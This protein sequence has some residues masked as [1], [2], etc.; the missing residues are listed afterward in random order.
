MSDFNKMTT[1]QLAEILKGK[2]LAVKS[3][4][5]PEFKVLPNESLG[6]KVVA[7]FGLYNSD[8]DKEARPL[9]LESIRHLHNLQRTYLINRRASPSEYDFLRD[10]ETVRKDRRRVTIKGWVMW[11]GQH[12]E[13]LKDDPL[14]KEIVTAGS[15]FTLGVDAETVNKSPNEIDVV[16]VAA[17]YKTAYERLESVE[18]TLEA[19]AGLRAQKEREAREA[20]LAARKAKEEEDRQKRIEAQKAK[21]AEAKAEAEAKRAKAEAERQAKIA[22]RSQKFDTTSMF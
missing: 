11:L 12:H 21:D 5:I 1:E 14:R 9:L 10:G 15:A 6:Q 22:E 7:A 19:R 17:L 8:K 18:K 3:G 20:E 13:M 4:F 16:A 2:M